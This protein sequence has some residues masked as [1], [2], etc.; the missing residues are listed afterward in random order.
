M[1]R[2]ARLRS[3]N[4][5]PT[6]SLG[7]AEPLPAAPE[8]SPGQALDFDTVYAELFP[9]VWRSLRALGVGEPYLDDAAQD[10]F[11][12]VHRRLHEFEG[13]SSL[14]TWLFAIVEHV[15]FNHRRT[16][17]RKL[18][19]LTPLEDTHGS[20]DPG[21]HRSTEDREVA[22]FLQRFL[23]SLDDG[24]RTLFVLVLVEQMSAPE[25]AQALRI[26]LNTAYS[27]IRA[28]KHAFRQASLAHQ[29]SKL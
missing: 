2:R 24:K 3:D 5:Q 22:R 4:G 12:V 14:R 26:P 10:V 19:R 13:R 1:F 20:A 21:P 17:R 8:A 23:D 16:V 11:L 28:I 6:R 9:F 7:P 15:A 27:R 18:A 29:E 25:V